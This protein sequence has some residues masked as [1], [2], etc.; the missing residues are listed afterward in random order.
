MIC[1][2]LIVINK[3]GLHARAS[4]LLS[5]TALKFQ[6]SI[7]MKFKGRSIDTKSIL[8]VMTM[9]GVQGSEVEICINGSDEEQAMDTISNLFQNRFN[10][11][12]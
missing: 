4:A 5:D 3:L 9:G 11:K 1:K 2:N 12:E 7:I 6:S 8:D 10:E